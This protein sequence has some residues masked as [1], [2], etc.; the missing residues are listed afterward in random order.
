MTPDDPPV[1]NRWSEHQ[2]RLVTELVRTWVLDNWFALKASMTPVIAAGITE[3]VAPEM[4][5][6]MLLTEIRCYY[7]EGQ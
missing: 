3:Q 5:A 6:S 4:I 1:R 7:P 2:D